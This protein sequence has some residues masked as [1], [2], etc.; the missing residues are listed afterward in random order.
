MFGFAP[1]DCCC[2]G[3]TIECPDL[4]DFCTSCGRTVDEASQYELVVEGLGNC[5]GGPPTG[6]DDCPDFNGSYVTSFLNFDSGTGFT[7]CRYKLV[8]GSGC[9]PSGTGTF[10][11]WV[12]IRYQKPS[13]LFPEIGCHTTIYGAI[14][15]GNQAP[16]PGP[17]GWAKIAGGRTLPGL[18][19]CEDLNGLNLFDGGGICIDDYNCDASNASMTLYRL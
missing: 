19:A 12:E 13:F 8:I 14:A 5:G 1:T 11:A 15:L 9:W 2:E 4:S 18:V 7:V 17:V 16:A 3:G 6:C 10:S